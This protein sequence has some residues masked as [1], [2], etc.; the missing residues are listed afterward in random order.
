MSFE[1][2]SNRRHTK[3]DSLSPSLVALSLLNAEKLLFTVEAAHPR[4][5][6]KP[7]KMEAHG[8]AN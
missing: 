6:Q 8:V 2:L 3:P 1:F 7:L 4:S 5:G